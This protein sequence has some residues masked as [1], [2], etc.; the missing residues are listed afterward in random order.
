[1]PRWLLRLLFQTLAATKELT[2]LLRVKKSQ[3]LLDSQ[4]L[5]AKLGKG[6]LVRQKHVHRIVRGHTLPQLVS[7][8]GEPDIVA[9]ADERLLEPS[10]R[11][12][13]HQNILAT[14]S[15]IDRN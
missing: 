8:S 10:R 2:L 5:H 3:R 14:A 7:A 9:A 13:A 6:G 11:A 12:V 15:V 1:M 4:P